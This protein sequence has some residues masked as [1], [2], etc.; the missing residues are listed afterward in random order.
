MFAQCKWILICIIAILFL[1]FTTICAT[2]SKFAG[3]VNN[4]TVYALEDEN[5]FVSDSTLNSLKLNISWIPPHEGRQPS[6]YSIIVTSIPKETDTNRLECTE[7]SEFYTVHNVTQLS[8]LVPPG[9]LLNG[10][11]T[12]QVRPNCTYK[13]QVHANPRAKPT[14]QLPEIVYTVPECIGRK[15]SCT[16]AKNT[17]PV[18]TVE[19]IQMTRKFVIKWNVTSNLNVQS[20]TISIGTPLLTSKAGHS[21][22]NITQIGNVTSATSTFIW[23]SKVH[24]QY[25]KVKSGYKIFV[26]AIDHRGCMGTRGNFTIITLEE[27]E[28]SYGNIIWIFISV[29]ICIVIFGCVGQYFVSI[30]NK[31]NEYQLLRLSR[32]LRTRQTSELSDCKSQWPE[33]TCY[34]QYKN[35]EFEVPYRCINLKYELGKG[36]FGKVY[37]GNLN[38]NMDTLVAVK[39]SQCS[40]LANESEARRQ[41][42]EEI[43]TMKTAGSHQHL[44]SLIGYCTSPDN[45]ICIL[46]EYMEGGDLLAYLHSKRK[47]ESDVIPLCSFEKSV[48]RYVNIIEKDKFKDEDLHDTIEKQQFMK[49]ALDIA[50]GMEYLETKEITHRDLA[51]RNILLTSDLTLKIS[52]FGLSRNGIYVINNIA[53]KVRQ[54][55]IRWMSPEAVRDY[56]FS[57]KSDVWSFGIVLW[58]IGTLGS[59]PYPNI[60]DEDLLRYLTQ[61]KCRLTCPDTIS[62][63]IYEI[64]CSCWNTTPQNRPSFA[65]LVLDLQTLHE[66]LYSVHETSNP[67]YMLLSQ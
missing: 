43:E 60:Q 15:C 42:L 4:I 27:T 11:S 47:I 16:K 56:T 17:L 55:P 1:H 39:M 12:M 46:L 40:D 20:Y 33:E 14:G 48:S 37:L 50:R 24:N 29:I 51:A 61:D 25:I 54:L 38:N 64:M 53:G 6:S 52:D 5:S 65:Q 35:D 19:T 49:F 30:Y 3:V 36:Q 26:T 18:P 63:D 59:F 57:S 13:I 31:N 8:L 58:E 67:C 45:P 32:V 62:H 44:V 28:T 66:S 41:L 2:N 7:D 9:K 21:V 22:Y 10:M 34:K 23:D